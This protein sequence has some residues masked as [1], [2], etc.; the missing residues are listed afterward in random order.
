[1][2][3]NISSYLSCTATK[4]F[5]MSL[6]SPN[7]I[8]EDGTT[9]NEDQDADMEDDNDNA[10]NANNNKNNVAKGMCVE[11]ADQLASLFCENCQDD[12]CQ[13]CFTALHR[14]GKRKLH[15]AK[16]IGNGLVDIL[17]YDTNAEY[18]DKMQV[19]GSLDGSWFEAR[20]RYIPLRLTLDERKVLRLLSA[21]LHVS[22]YTD[23][24][25]S[26]EGKAKRNVQQ[27]RELC[28]LL[29]GLAGAV[30]RETGVQ[31]A[32]DRIFLPHEEFYHEALEIARR[33][34]IMNPDKMRSEYGKLVYLLQDSLLP[35]IHELVKLKLVK[36]IRTVYTLLEERKCVKLL[37]DPLMEIATREI[38]SDGKT[39]PQ[40]QREIKEKERAIKV[41]SQKYASSDLKSEE[42]E[43]CIYSIGD[44][45][46][47]LRGT[48]DTIDQMLWHLTHYFSPHAV[49]EGYSL[50]IAAG[51]SGSRL[52]HSHSRQYH[53]VLQSL[54]LW[55]E[56]AHDMFRLWI[57]A[58]EDLL[59]GTTPYKL[60]DTGQGR[61]RVQSA[62]RIAK[63]M[64]AIVRRVQAR[65]GDAWV[66][67]AVVHLG[68][69]NVPNAL[70]FI[71]KY[72]QISR[73]LNPIVITLRRVEELMDD[74][75][76][77]DYIVHKFGSL[78]RCRKDILCDFFRHAFDGSG[79][80]NWFDAGSCIDGRL[81]SAWHWCSQ[82]DKKPFYPIFLLSG[83]IGFD[84]QF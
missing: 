84:G 40:I 35:E 22:A 46:S 73:I 23:R 38:I 75:A 25:D 47:F 78:D 55:R 2:G 52:T 9:A 58:E 24:V 13:L 72:S 59:D 81:T 33:Y 15:S 57:L 18:D 5:S 82:I 45:H 68:D 74:S 4:Q 65:V 79:A 80:D 37:H 43:R 62:P 77:R 49:E 7:D 61:H 41:L 71:D 50:A 10:T 11:C 42:I 60:R 26:Q 3:T 44:N 51:Q 36:P 12:F 19:T 76:I 27:L 56:V 20:A 17:G 16:K 30:D 28:A 63:A 70:M 67:S 34:K 8:L 66:G 1:V 14:R 83:F 39:R 69:H 29:C 54:A 6:P 64:S 53:Y 32:T 48:R 31:V 21:G